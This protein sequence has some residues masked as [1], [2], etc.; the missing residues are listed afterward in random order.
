MPRHFLPTYDG[1][2]L[3]I[4]SIEFIIQFSWQENGKCCDEKNNK[5]TIERTHIL[6]SP[7][8]TIF[9]VICYNWGAESKNGTEKKF[10]VKMKH[11]HIDMCGDV[12]FWFST[13]S[14]C[15]FYSQR[16][17]CRKT[18]CIRYLCDESVIQLHI[19][20]HIR[21]ALAISDIEMKRASQFSPHNGKH[22]K[23]K[24]S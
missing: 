21:L 13:Y 2:I 18:T 24:N 17:K 5:N 12:P 7:V 6:P 11:L 22:Y 16:F 20:L 1:L 3:Q 23:I 4:S 14:W 19:Q 8:S 10:R 15:D 9:V